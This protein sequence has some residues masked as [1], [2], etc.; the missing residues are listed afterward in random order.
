MNF[1]IGLSKICQTVDF[2]SHLVVMVVINSINFYS[3]YPYR[4]LNFLLFILHFLKYYFNYLSKRED[5]LRKTV[6]S[7]LKLTY[8]SVF[9][10]KS[11]LVEAIKC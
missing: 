9:V 2:T 1:A 7:S 3:E 10:P 11:I 4:L 6:H 8:F 5:S